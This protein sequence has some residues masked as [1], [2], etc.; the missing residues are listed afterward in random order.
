MPDIF[1]ADDSRQRNPTRQGMGPLVATGF[2][3]VPSENVRDLER[4][5]DNLCRG[6][7]F[8]AG[9]AGEFKWSPG[10]ELWMRDNLVDQART[11]FFA[12]ALDL[13]VEAGCR[14]SVIIAD[15]SRRTATG[16]PDH[17]TDVTAL[18]FE[19]VEWRLRRVNRIGIIVVDRPS[20][21]RDAENKFLQRCLETLSAGTD[22]VALKRVAVNV[23]STP[24]YL[25]S[26]LQLADLVTSCTTALVAG[27]NRYAPATF[28]HIRPL[29]DEDGGR[30]GGIGLKI[31]PHLRYMNLYHWLLGDDYLR[32]GNTG[33][34]LPDEAYPYGRSQ[35]HER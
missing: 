32:Q 9:D 21:G 22:Y 34:P 35:W 31:H 13:A 12:Q 29:L 3:H 23:V 25:I 30:T 14:A 26:C 18:L 1:F 24:S 11:D 10:R 7:G 5:L 27:E 16:A 15:E 20:G 19:R 17:Q 8:P 4:A 33:Y 2:V 28:E 6:V